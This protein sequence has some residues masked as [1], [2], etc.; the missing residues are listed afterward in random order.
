MTLPSN[1]DRQ[2]AAVAS[3]GL[4]ASYA[5]ASDPAGLNYHS[6]GRLVGLVYRAEATFKSGTTLTSQTF[7]IQTARTL[8]NVADAAATDWTDVALFNLAALSSAA[9]AVD[10]A[11]TAASAKTV[12]LDLF[13]PDARGARNY[14]RVLVKAAGTAAAGDSFALFVP[15]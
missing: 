11:I 12:G 14:Y 5:V 10:Q 7:K 2:V 9:S 13:V 1:T 6:V 15:K 3:G 8:T 4:G